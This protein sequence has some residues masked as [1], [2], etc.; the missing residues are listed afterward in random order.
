MN[1][2][3]S[4]WIGMVAGGVVQRCWRA[5]RSAGCVFGTARPYFAIATIATAQTL[6]LIFLRVSRFRLGR[7]GHRDSDLGSAPLMMQFETKTHS[8]YYVA[9][10]LLAL[11]AFDHPSDRR[12]G[13]AITS[14]PSAR[15]RALRRRSASM[16]QPSA[17][18]T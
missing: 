14:S 2:D 17:I 6:M 11:R 18:S 1:H 3:V 12:S 9:L 8:Y 16:R 4:P 7:R 5:C 10:D 13:S 15:M